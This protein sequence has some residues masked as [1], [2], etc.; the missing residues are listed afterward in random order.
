MS[1]ISALDLSFVKSGYPHKSCTVIM[2]IKWCKA[3]GS[4]YKFVSILHF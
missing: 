4:W 2:R 3:I 1:V